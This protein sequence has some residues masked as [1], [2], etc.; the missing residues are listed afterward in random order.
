MQPP[1]E[2]LLT[3]ALPA[4]EELR[5]RPQWVCWRKEH[6]RG[7]PTKIPYT[8]TTGQCAK[9]DAPATW[10]SYSQAVHALSTVGYSGVGYM[11]HR[12]Y[13]GID[14]DHCVGEGG[15]IDPWAQAYL[16]RLP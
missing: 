7:K 13:T 10:S 16:D 11:F 15:R 3:L 4:L 1:E 12:D 2:Y 14:L 5:A 9:S 8:P 6:R